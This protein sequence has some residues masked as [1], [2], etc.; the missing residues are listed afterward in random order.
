MHTRRLQF[1]VSFG[2]D[3]VVSSVAVAPIVAATYASGVKV[4][5]RRVTGG[6]KPIAATMTTASPISLP[7]RVR[8]SW[9]ER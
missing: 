8:C 2:H 9:I 1:T 5:S 7:G 3:A 4:P 6:E